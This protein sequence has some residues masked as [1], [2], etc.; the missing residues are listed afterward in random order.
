[1]WKGFLVRRILGV[2]N[3][4]YKIVTRKI[5][6]NDSQFQQKGIYFALLGCDGGG[7]VDINDNWT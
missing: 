4:G 6:F 3:I 2:G 5:L 1:M 7:K